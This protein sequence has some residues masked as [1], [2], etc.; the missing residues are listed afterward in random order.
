[1][2]MSLAEA[3]NDLGDLDRRAAAVAAIDAAGNAAIP[4]LRAGLDHPHWRVRHMSARLLDDLALDEETVQ[5][6][7]HV[8]HN[9]SHRKVR[10]QAYHA[11]GCEP[12]KPDGTVC[13]FDKV[14]MVLD[15]LADRS[16]RVR[17]GG[18]SGL[19][20]A[21]VLGDAD[22][23]RIRRALADAAVDPDAIIAG[24]A[25]RALAHLSTISA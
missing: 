23:P 12:C 8:A 11:A 9:D 14:A 5:V 22:D 3:V 17:R 2:S 4:A 6:L 1:M 21:A 10:A 24:R 19:L 20:F 15:E 16:L 18:A 13:E 25:A 7:L